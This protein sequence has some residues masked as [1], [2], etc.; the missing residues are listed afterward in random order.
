[1]SEYKNVYDVIAEY[2]IKNGY[3]ALYYDGCGC[4]IND[5]AP[6]DQS[7]IFCSFGAMVDCE[8]CEN[9]ATCEDSSIELGY[10]ACEIAVPIGWCEKAVK[11]NGG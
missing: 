7:C 3:N 2:M 8:H 5:L 4:S 10:D 6:C 11:V 1:M 9:L